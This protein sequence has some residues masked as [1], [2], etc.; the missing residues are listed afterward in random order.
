MNLDYTQITAVLKTEVPKQYGFRTIWPF[1]DYIYDQDGT[2]VK[3][4]SGGPPATWE[5][6]EEDKEAEDY[7]YD[8]DLPP[9]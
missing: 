1:S 7:S 8:G 6:T 2:I 4:T 5:P 3:V 9:R